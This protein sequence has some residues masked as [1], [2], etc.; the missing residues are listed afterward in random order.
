MCKKVLILYPQKSYADAV[1]AVGFIPVYDA[2]S[3]ADC[4]LLTGGGDVS[5]CAYSAVDTN[6]KDVDIKRDQL[7]FFYVNKFLKADKPILGIC[8]GLQ[9]VNV[10]FGGTL[11]QKISNHDQ[12]DGKDRKHLVLNKKG[13]LL[14]DIYGDK[15][16]V[17]SAH[18]QCVE[19]IGKPLEGVSFSLD[20][21]VECLTYRKIILTQFHPERMGSVGLKIFERFLASCYEP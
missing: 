5:P 9:V 13:A 8:R 17:N 16:L 7:E 10:F 4:L 21:V 15:L 20:G 11:K 2:V 3:T 12:L 18:R 19:K 1:T 14:Y 6:C